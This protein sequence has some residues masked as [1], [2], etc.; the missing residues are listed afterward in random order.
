MDEIKQ[1][2]MEL[3][4]KAMHNLYKHYKN[5]KSDMESLFPEGITSTELDII[6]I[7]FSQ[8]EIIIKEVGEYLGLAGSTLTS[9]IDRLEQKKLLKRVVSARNRRSFGLELTQE[10]IQ[11]NTIHQDAERQIWRRIL[12][13]FDTDQERQLFLKLLDIISQEESKIED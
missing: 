9:A 8:P 13:K 10:G 6:K 3:M 5:Y 1:D 4:D 12:G 7:V 2:Q 11:I